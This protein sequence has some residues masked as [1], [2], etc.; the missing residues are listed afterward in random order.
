MT[1]PLVGGLSSPPGAG[2]RGPPA[3]QRGRLVGEAA[4]FLAAFPAIQSAIK[5]YG[6]KQGMRIQLDVPES[7]MGEALKLLMWRE[8]VLRVTVGPEDEERQRDKWDTRSE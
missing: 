7:E 6:D 1:P 8:R 5:V 2:V 4:S 3:P